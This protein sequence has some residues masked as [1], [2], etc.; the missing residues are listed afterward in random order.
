MKKRN[1]PSF[2][3]I[4]T[5]DVRYS[6]K[7][8][9][10]EKL[11]FSE[12]TALSN[13]NGY[14]TAGNEYFSQVYGISER[15]VTRRLG[16]LAKAGFIKIVIE[17]NT[18]KGNGVIRK[19][20]PL[21]NQNG[22]S[23]G[24]SQK[25]RGGIAKNGEGVVAKNGEQNSTSLEQENIERERKYTIKKERQE[26]NQK[27]LSPPENLNHEAWSLWITYKKKIRNNY[28]TE[29]SQLIK[30]KQLAVLS[31]DNQMRC[32]I[33]SIGNEYKGLFP[34]KF[35]GVK[36]DP[37]KQDTRAQKTIQ[38]IRKNIGLALGRDGD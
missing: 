4:L 6:D 27:K 15:T 13:K 2:F 38:D 28:K 12:V 20:Y 37:I 5:A 21:I 11:L 24:G 3:S 10:L 29:M 1:N 16:K 17:Q 8:K 30:M 22:A 23:G 31:K 34:E 25:W 14:C 33:D 18:D 36:H 7:I 35:K 19:I 32:V 9:A 26:K